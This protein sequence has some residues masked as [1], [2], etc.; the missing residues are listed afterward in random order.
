MANG[1]L[2]R[3]ATFRAEAKIAA[4]DLDAAVDFALQMGPAGAALRDADAAT[5][6]TVATA[7][8]DALEP[9]SGPDGVRMGSATWI[10][11]A[12]R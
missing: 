7:V 6:D 11:T 10:V 12:G 2:L 9:F 4:N 3:R 1:G 5:R 8:R